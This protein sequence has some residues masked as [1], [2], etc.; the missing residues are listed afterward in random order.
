MVETE[1]P[2]SPVAGETNGNLDFVGAAGSPVDPMLGPLQNTGGFTLT[3][4]PIPGSLAM[5][6]TNGD[7]TT[8]FSTDQRGRDRIFRDTMDIGA[9]EYRP[10]IRS[11]ERKVRKTNRLAKKQS[12]SGT[13]RN[14]NDSKARN[15][16]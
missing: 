12:R 9:V 7:S 4:N 5:D 2:A 10:L 11:L 13:R 16:G 8:L 15:E 14:L 6:P 3:L 1:F